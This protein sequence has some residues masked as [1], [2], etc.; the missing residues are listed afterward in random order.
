MTWLE[1][2]AWFVLH[3]PKPERVRGKQ[4]LEKKGTLQKEITELKKDLR[5]V[6]VFCCDVENEWLFQTCRSP[7]N[8]MMGL[9][10]GNKH[11]S[12]RGTPAVE[13][14]E[15]AEVTRMVS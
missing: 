11:A 5:Q 1:L 10:I 14:E 15:A 9:A 12:I 2:Y 8:R 13:A 4:L 6:T 7:Q 3:S